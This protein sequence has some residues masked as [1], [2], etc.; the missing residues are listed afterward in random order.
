[1]IDSYDLH[2]LAVVCHDC[3]CCFLYTTAIVWTARWSAA[4][5]GK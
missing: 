2:C 3:H 1:L 5:G 4:R